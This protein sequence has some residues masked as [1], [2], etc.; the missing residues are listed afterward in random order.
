MPG[1]ISIAS[2]DEPIE[3]SY[4]DEEEHVRRVERLAVR[5]LVVGSYIV[6]PGRTDGRLNSVASQVTVW[7]KPSF[8][9]DSV[10][11]NTT[12]RRGT[13]TYVHGSIIHFN[14]S[15]AVFDF[16]LVLLSTGQLWWFIIGDS[17]K[18][19]EQFMTAPA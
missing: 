16:A 17:V 8:V 9:A 19:L 7:Q 18:S 14:F 6:I 5:G 11:I 15:D 3:E 1:H 2:V 13:F 4:V 10:M 12:D